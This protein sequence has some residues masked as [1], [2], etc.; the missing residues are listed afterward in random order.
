MSTVTAPVDALNL[1]VAKATLAVLQ[2]LPKMPAARLYTDLVFQFGHSHPHPPSFGFPIPSTGPILASGCMS[3]LINGLP[4]ARNGDMGLAVWCG[5]YFPIFEVMTGSSHVFIGGSRAA[6]QVMDVTYHCLPDPFGGKYGLG[7]LDVAMAVFGVGMSALG[8]AAAMEQADAADANAEK[9]QVIASESASDD[10]AIADAASAAASAAAAGV[11]AATAAA[12]LAADAA[13][14]AMGLLMGKDPGVGFPFGMI[15]MGSPNVLIGG[16]PMPGWMT[17]LKGLGKMLKPLIRRIQLKMPEGRL[18]QAMC[19]LTGHPVEIAS[20][21][22]FTSKTDFEIDGRV[23][24]SFERI[25]DT[26]A[27]D[28]EGSLGWGWIHPYEQ[29]LWE[30]KK[31]NCLVLRNNENRQVRFDKLAVGERQFQPLERT[32]L[33]R[34]SEFEF[35]LFDCKDGLTYR[36]GRIDEFSDDFSDEKTVLRLLDISDRNGNRVELEYKDKLLSK[37]RN[38]TETY[39]ELLHQ[40][41]AGKTRLVEIQQHLKNGQTISLMRFGY[42]E[43]A[44]LHTA[45]DRTYQPFIYEYKNHLLTRET[46]RNKLSFYFEYEGAGTSARCVHT[47]GDGNIYERWLEYL[48]KS[49]ITKVSDGLGGETV[50]HYNNLDLVTKIFNA[51]GGVYEFEYGESGELLK[52]IDELKRLTEYQYDEQLNCI[53]KKE[54]DEAIFQI[55]YDEFCQPLVV[56]DEVESKWLHEYDARGNI[57]ATVNP[58]KARREYEY[59]SLGDITMLRDALGNKTT[60]EWT[61]S[62]Q[63]KLV[64][65]PLGEK[66]SYSYNERDFLTEVTEEFT[67][68]KTNYLYD[69]AGRI[70]RISEIN[71]RRETFSVQRFEYDDQSNLLFYI[72]SL[73]NK[74][75][76]GYAGFDK[77]VSRTDALGYSRQF[78]YDREERLREIINERGENYLFKYDSLYRLTEEIGFDRAK[79]SYK[80]NQAGELVYQQDALNREIFYQYDAVGRITKVLRSDSSTTTYV[81]DKCGRIIKGENPNST[82]NI[83]YDAAW[84]VISETQNGQTVNYEY[85]AEGRRIARILETDETK[86]SRI[87]YEYNADGELSLVRIGERSIN[88]ERDLAGRLTGRQLPNGLREQFNYDVNGRLSGQKVSVGGGGRELFSRGYEWDALGNVAGITDSLRGER[89]YNLD[90]TERL[91]KVERV[92]TGSLINL[93]ETGE[94]SLSKNALPAEKRLWQADERAGSNFGQTREVEEFQY[95]GDGNLLERKSNVRGS[96]QF[97]YGAGDRLNQQNKTQ[98]IYDAV[99]N[100]IQKRQANGTFISYEYDADNQLISV[101]TETGGKIEFQYDAFGRRTAKISDYAIT[102]FLWDGNV[103]LSEKKDSQSAVEYVHEEYVPLAKIRDSDIETYHTDYLGTPKEVTNQQGELIW[104]GNYDEYGKVITVKALT[105]QNIRF[106]GQYEDVETGLYY[107]R[108]RYYDAD[109]CRYINQDPIGLLGDYNLYD[110]CQNPITG[111]DPLGLVKWGHYLENT[112]GVPK[113]KKG[114][115]YRPHAHHIVFKKGRASQQADLNIS[116]AILKAHGIDYL[117]GRENLVWAPNKNHSDEAAA[118]VRRALQRAARTKGTKAKKRAAVRA[119]LRRMGKKFADDTIC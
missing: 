63:I 115:M 76:Y 69:D 90:A 24:I 113:P 33:E 75:S 14:M 80:Y 98:Y 35:K 23:P 31:R 87:E 119:A 34:T 114:T 70:K 25:Y 66:T 60:F 45:T 96:R 104:Q 67:G 15:T 68:L 100:L 9:A 95:D 17:I 5:G 4:A 91:N 74:T 112:L 94:K 12:Q 72:D 107:N 6:R 79:T 3:V 1:A 22:M 50:Y 19:A 118:K 48:P 109:G 41:V 102:G 106:Q 86:P 18:R 11:G 10:Q 101:S 53:S 40:I 44:E 117:M 97:N 57:F 78:K 89:R 51:E 61:I 93:P 47:W 26:S 52:E 65:S 37:I 82:V 30:S 38:G 42:N 116:K 73:G 88:Y 99:G 29:H 43:E 32:W 13:A 7:K 58:L 62:G 111:V 103:L 92:M 105:E 64:I 39:V 77:L 16:F 110:Y 36:F 46:N 21:R 54:A 108:F 55:E 8:L 84:Q 27:I 81:Y 85:D 71:P 49:R 2:F 83:T 56:I 20:G 59:N 28:Y